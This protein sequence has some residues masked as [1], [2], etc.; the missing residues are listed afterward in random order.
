MQTCKRCNLCTAAD[1]QRVARA[2]L[3]DKLEGD[4]PLSSDIKPPA[5]DGS[6]PPRMLRHWSPRPATRMQTPRD[7]LAAPRIDK[8]IATSDPPPSPLCHDR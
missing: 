2:Y 6:R 5:G 8:T 1:V 7:G 3:V 4:D